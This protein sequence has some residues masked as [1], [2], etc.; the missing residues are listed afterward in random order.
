MIFHYLM[1]RFSEKP[2]MLARRMNTEKKNNQI[3]R[4]GFSFAG[5][6]S[7][8]VSFIVHCTH[9]Y[10]SAGQ[11]FR[12]S[13]KIVANL[14]NSSRFSDH[15]LNSNLERSSRNRFTGSYS[16]CVPITYIIMQALIHSFIAKHTLRP[17]YRTKTV[18]R[19]PAKRVSFMNSAFF[20]IMIQHIYNI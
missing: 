9:Y 7:C 11:K 17:P 4:G 5:N 20:I 19:L 16:I 3:Y 15:A 18:N 8:L 6:K 12:L 10:L 1:W 13:N 14:L 2:G